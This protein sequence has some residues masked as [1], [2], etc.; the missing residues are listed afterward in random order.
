MFVNQGSFKH[1]RS[2]VAKRHEK[3][4]EAEFSP[5]RMISTRFLLLIVVCGLA[6]PAAAYTK[7]QCINMGYTQ[8]GTATYSSSC[9]CGSL[10]FTISSSGP[11]CASRNSNGCVV[12]DGDCLYAS[13]SA[14]SHPNCQYSYSAWTCSTSCG[15]GTLRRTKSC[16]GASCETG[17]TTESGGSCTA[18]AAAAWAVVDVWR[19][20]WHLHSQSLVQYKL[21]WLLLRWLGL[22]VAKLLSDRCQSTVVH[23][24]ALPV[25][26]RAAVWIWGGDL[27]TLMQRRMWFVWL[28][29]NFAPGLLFGRRE[30]A[31]VV[32]LV[33]LSIL[34][35]RAVWVRGDHLFS[36]VQRGLW[37]L[38]HWNN[39][40]ARCLFG[41]R[42]LTAVDGVVPHAI[43]Q[44]AAVRDRRHLLQP[45][46]QRRLWLVR[47]GSSHA[48]GPLLGSRKHQSMVVLVPHSSMQRDTVW[49]RVGGACAHL[50][51]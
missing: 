7:Q 35:C 36:L 46:M 44:C 50:Q 41:R 31:T 32:Y 49:L 34:Q 15:T 3:L 9:P 24:V 10:Y 21:L 23:V 40:S 27:Y 13:C 37:L 30:L 39:H 8:A 47:H 14:G 20:W 12:F 43:L 51:W 1:S 45:L 5:T 16:P 29:S 28:W 18:G 25:L 38:R 19:V 33:P 4:H 48:T 22:R 11:S 42:E 6:G 2:H 26:Q 17:T